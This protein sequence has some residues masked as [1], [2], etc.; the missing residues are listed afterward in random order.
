MTSP[1]DTP[2]DYV[3][4][5]GQKS[6]GIAEILGASSPRKWDER[7]GYALSGAT[8]VYKGN[9]LAKFTLQLRLY[10][11]EDWAAWD[12]W[13][14]LVQRP[15][16]GARA[17]A[18]EIVHPFLEALE[19]RSV[20]V[21][22]VLQPIQTGDGE[23]TIEVKFIEWRRPLVALSRPDGARVT[24]AVE[25]EIFLNSA[26]IESLNQQLATEVTP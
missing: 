13:R 18:L 22:D 15:P 3:L 16:V 11:V 4:L 10:S 24:D 7:G 9:G 1:L 23:W 17:R 8:L 12:A 26:E 2:V 20:V 14:P 21:E 5:A 19:I 6:P 25:A